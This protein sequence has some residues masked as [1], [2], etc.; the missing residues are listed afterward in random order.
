MNRQGGTIS[1]PLCYRTWDLW[2]F[3]LVKQHASG[4]SAHFRISEHFHRPVKM[5]DSTTDR[6][7][8]AQSTITNTISDLGDSPDRPIC[9]QGE[10]TDSSLLFFDFAPR[11]FGNSC[12]V[13][14][15][16]R[17]ACICVPFNLSH[18]QSSATHGAVLC[19]I[20]LIASNRPRR[21]WYPD[22]LKFL[23]AYP[24]E[25]QDICWL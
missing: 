23:I 2:N 7:V 25:S 15:F 16:G 22:L 24:R 20:I 21:R 4:C 17:H 13:N 1:P 18:T 6:M 11:C 3:A 14:L 9:I 10:Q 8:N 12:S 19:Q 5:L